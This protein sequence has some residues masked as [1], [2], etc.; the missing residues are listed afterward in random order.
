M[1]LKHMLI[2]L[3]TAT[4]LLAGCSD[5]PEQEPTEIDIQLEEETAENRQNEQT[6]PET[7]TANVAVINP[8]DYP[9]TGDTDT[10]AAINAAEYLK[11]TDGATLSKYRV[12][13]RM[14]EPTVDDRFEPIHPATAAETVSNINDGW[15]DNAVNYITEYAPSGDD[16][17][18]IALEVLSDATLGAFEEDIAKEAVNIVYSE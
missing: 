4:L 6:Q 12:F 2:P 10:S 16:A 15:V 13:E 17:K 3:T 7:P 1:K 14:V 5:E 11:T 9:Q 18:A 8:A